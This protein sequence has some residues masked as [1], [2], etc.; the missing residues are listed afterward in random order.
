VQVAI[1]FK[2]IGILVRRLGFFPALL[3]PLQVPLPLLLALRLTV[4]VTVTVTFAFT[5]RFT[6]TVTIAVQLTVV[7]LE[8]IFVFHRICVHGPSKIVTVAVVLVVIISFAIQCM[9]S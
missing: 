2:V 3:T 9:L 5:V 8:V 6:F 1:A 4:T 7:L